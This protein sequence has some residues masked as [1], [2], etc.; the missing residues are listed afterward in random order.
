[1]RRAWILAIFKENP[2]STRA[3]G[4]VIARN[5]YAMAWII[6]ARLQAIASRFLRGK[7]LL[8]LQAALTPYGAFFMPWRLFVL[9]AFLKRLVGLLWRSLLAHRRPWHCD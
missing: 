6:I 3:F 5:F 8:A 7:G 9:P 2:R 4:I 1:M